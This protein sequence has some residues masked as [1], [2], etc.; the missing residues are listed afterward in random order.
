MEFLTTRR[1]LPTLNSD[2]VLNTRTLSGSLWRSSLM[3]VNRNSVHRSRRFPSI[4]AD[5]CLGRSDNSF[6]VSYPRYT[7]GATYSSR[8][9]VKGSMRCWLDGNI[10][11]F[12]RVSISSVKSSYNFEGSQLLDSNALFTLCTSLK[13][14]LR[15]SM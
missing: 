8:L 3:R 7:L 10:T 9:Q 5:T 2:M 13:T 6:S 1:V 11:L 14:D 12:T 4:F 15:K